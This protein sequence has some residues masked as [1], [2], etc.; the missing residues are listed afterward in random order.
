MDGHLRTTS[1][2]GSRI[3]GTIQRSLAEGINRR[4]FAL[5]K[6]VRYPIRSMALWLN[7]TYDNLLLQI[8]LLFHL[9][10]ES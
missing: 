3:I 6:A 10:E 5:N 1:G 2:S 7:L 4:S 9:K 8:G